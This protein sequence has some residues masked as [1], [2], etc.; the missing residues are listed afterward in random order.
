MLAFDKCPHLAVVNVQSQIMQKRGEGG[1]GEQHKGVHL[2][3]IN[4][5]SKSN[6]Y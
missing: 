5:E 3:K 2:Q 6:H 1:N 4:G